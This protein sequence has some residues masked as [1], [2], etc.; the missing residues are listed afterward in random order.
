M[1]KVIDYSILCAGDDDFIQ[2]VKKSIKN[3]WQPF[4]SV[5]YSH[6]KWHQAMVVYGKDEK[7]ELLQ[8]QEDLAKLKI[9]QE[10]DAIKSGKSVTES[11]VTKGSKSE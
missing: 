3:G 7:S 10:I 11:E 8:L 5:H 9:Q 1:P 4:G 6:G 2:I